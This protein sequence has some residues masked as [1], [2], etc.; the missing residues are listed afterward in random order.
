MNK[1][2]WKRLSE[3]AA[4]DDGSP[5]TLPTSMIL[6][7][8]RNANFLIPHSSAFVPSCLF[9][10]SPFRSLG[11]S[12]IVNVFLQNVR[13]TQPC[14]DRPKPYEGTGDGRVFRSLIIYGSTE[15]EMKFCAMAV[16]CTRFVRIVSCFV[17]SHESARFTTAFFSVRQRPITFPLEHYLYIAWNLSLVRCSSRI[18]S[19]L[20]KFY[21]TL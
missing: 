1:L 7:A 18:D 19:F 6:E 4:G 5:S 12:F 3:G 21:A 10:F 2:R 8:G 20:S 14:P 15:L 9:L 16:P 13:G 11:F 17:T